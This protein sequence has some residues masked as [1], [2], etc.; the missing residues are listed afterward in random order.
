[1]NIHPLK[2]NHCYAALDG[3]AESSGAS[4]TG[5]FLNDTRH[6][7]DYRWDF[8]PL[9]SVAHAEGPDWMFRQW[10]LYEGRTQVMSVARTFRLLPDGFIDE[11]LIG[12]E[13]ADARTC[14]PS[15]SMEADFRD[16]FEVRGRARQSIG[17]NDV[18]RDGNHFRYLSQDGVSCET[19]MT[20]TGFRPGESIA[21]KAGETHRIFVCGHFRSSHFGPQTGAPTAPWTAAARSLRETSSHAEQRAF[22]DIDMLMA[23]SPE[24]PV[25]LTGVPYYVNVFGRDSLIA[26]WFLLS[27]APGVADNTLR[28]LA[29]HQGQRYDPVTLEAP[30]K[31][32][33][34]LR[35]C[36]LA[37]TLDVPFGRYYGTADASALFVLLMRDHWTQTGQTALVRDLADAWR[38]AIGWCRSA[39][40]GDGLLRYFTQQSGRGLKNNSWK[41]SEDSMS[42]SDGRLAEG[43]LAVVEVQGYFAAALDAAADL[44]EVLQGDP[45]H[46]RVLRREAE[47]LRGV[48]D[49]TF[50]NERLGIHAIALDETGRQCDVVSSNPGHLLWAGVLSETRAMAV[51]DRLMQPD[52]WSGWGVRC[53]STREK[54][55]QPLSYHNG[56]VWP[57]DNGMIAAGCQRYGLTDACDKIWQGMGEAA[58]AFE[59]LRLPELIGGYHRVHGRPPIPYLETCS[60]QA[61][62]AAALVFRAMLRAV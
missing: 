36:E 57:H 20:F 13:S 58:V 56:S 60:P 2:S 19:I 61:W 27:A 34:E 24:G 14:T 28:V 11:V 26:S 54:R 49:N 39:R 50:W 23:T 10:G 12:N 44:E 53:L 5:V 43:R 9:D 1:M 51:V 25:V 42:F 6:I 37:R 21:L 8:G 32:A 4:K 48:I 47:D 7:S 55:Y 40:D 59:D 15:L 16:I 22:E 30:G 29:A 62:A 41:D 38:G 33:H 35:D 52:M 31:I 46:I 3:R 45:D 17:R 18:E